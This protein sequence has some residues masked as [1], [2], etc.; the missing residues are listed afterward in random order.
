MK[1]SVFS[2]CLNVLSVAADVHVTETE[3]YDAIK[4]RTVPY[5]TIMHNLDSTLKNKCLPT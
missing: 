1:S 3:K 2:R 5:V 4:Y